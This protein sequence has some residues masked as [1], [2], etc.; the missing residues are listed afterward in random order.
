[1][2]LGVKIRRKK[3]DPEETKC[4]LTQLGMTD[5]SLRLHA[6]FTILAGSSFEFTFPNEV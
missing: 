5:V 2:N 1:M 4:L 3:K 6:C